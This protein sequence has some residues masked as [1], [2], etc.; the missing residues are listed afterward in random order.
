MTNEPPWLCWSKSPFCGQSD[1]CSPR[2]WCSRSLFGWSL[3]GRSSTWPLEAIPLAVR[4]RYGFNTEQIGLG[5]ISMVVGTILAAIIS[6]C[7]RF[8][9]RNTAEPPE[10]RLYPACVQSVFLPV[11]LFLARIDY[12][13]IY[14]ISRAPSGMRHNWDF[15]RSV[16]SL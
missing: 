11:G 12:L 16:S 10:Y 4:D 15:L 3:P 6:I 1:T 5:S 14:T 9:Q 13:P 2:L 8:M 7:I